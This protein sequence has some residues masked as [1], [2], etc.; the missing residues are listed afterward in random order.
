ML[1]PTSL[2][3]SSS[4]NSFT[5]FLY[6]VLFPTSASCF[7][8]SPPFLGIF[9]GAMLCEPV[10]EA[11]YVCSSEFLPMHDETPHGLC[12]Q[13]THAMLSW[14]GLPDT[15]YCQWLVLI[16]LLIHLLLLGPLLGGT[17]WQLGT[18]AVEQ[19]QFEKM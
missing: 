10:H 4:H 1:S 19:L 12:W 9:I 2:L 14:D 13:L 5:S 16:Q 11:I 17:S 6:G 15:C 7:P 8:S 18:H 3:H